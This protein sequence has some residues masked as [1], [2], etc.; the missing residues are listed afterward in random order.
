MAAEEFGN[1]KRCRSRL[2]LD[3]RRLSLRTLLRRPDRSAR[4]K[5]LRGVFDHAF[6]SLRHAS[7]I[8]VE[9]EEQWQDRS[10]ALG[11]ARRI[12]AG[13]SLLFP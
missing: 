1:R 10:A 8:S 12:P 11:A 7:L 6:A 13:I 4:M 2:L 3:C 5:I 9:D